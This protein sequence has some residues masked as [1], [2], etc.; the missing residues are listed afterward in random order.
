MGAA[1]VRGGGAW[2]TVRV[3]AQVGH[4]IWCPDHCSLP[5][6][7]CPHWGHE[8]LKSGISV[9]HHA[10]GGH[11][12]SF[13]DEGEHPRFSTGPEGGVKEVRGAERQSCP[14]PQAATF[15]MPIRRLLSVSGGSLGGLE[16]PLAGFRRRTTEISAMHQKRQASGHLPR[17]QTR[18]HAPSFQDGP[19]V[20]I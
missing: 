9:S 1:P 4:W 8:N 15:R 6:R 11:L 7:C 18:C 19:T 16:P 5:E 17:L 3:V 12:E 2:G 13:H 14:L 20:G 10:A